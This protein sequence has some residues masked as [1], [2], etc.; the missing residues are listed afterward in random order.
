[1][2]LAPESAGF[3]SERLRRITVFLQ[4]K[5][6]RGE[7]PGMIATVARRGQTAYYQKFGHMDREAQ[8]PMRDDAIFIIASMTKPVTSVA[9][10]T[11]YE[12]G[13]FHLNTP[14]YEFIPGFRDTKVFVRETPGGQ[15]EL[16]DLREPITFRHL[17]THTAGLCYGGERDA[18][19]RLYA[20]QSQQL[21]TV[22]NE[23]LVEGL[24]KLPLA[25]QPGT[26]W[27]Y[28]F[29][30]DV[31]GRL[32]E[33]ISGQSLDVFMQERLFKPMGMVD[34]AF[35]VPPEKVD[36][37]ATVYGHTA[38]DPEL[39]RMDQIRPR[40]QPPAWFS[41]GGGL[42]STVHDYARFAQMLV[43]GGQL[44]GNRILGPRTVALYSMNLAPQ[45]ALPY[46]FNATDTNH[47]G[48]G[49]SLGTRVLMDV[50]ANGIA[51]SVGEF[52]WD[53]AHS[54][55]FWVDPKE[56]LYRLLMMQHNPNYITLHQRFKQLTYQALVD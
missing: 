15:M 6:D 17:F 37:V 21:R 24:A 52:G 50:A 41:G 29:A 3:S 54:T 46:S 20:A 43:N 55:Y 44:D 30:I 11:L 4:G 51:G 27:R 31:L 9:L 38:P 45:E 10:M 35:H 22:T 39:K 56:A 42:V 34:T 18:V 16:E 8:T 12:E 53:G 47:R 49:Y 23:L 26:H 19:D 5:V 32:A 14:V 25:F 36:R 33:V 2:N 7:M 40:F 13:H 1:M 28:S 48:Y